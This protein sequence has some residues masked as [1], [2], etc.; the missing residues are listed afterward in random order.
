VGGSGKIC[1]WRHPITHLSVRRVK[2][3]SRRRK[4]ALT[5]IRNIYLYHQGLL[6]VVIGSLFS[7]VPL[8][9]ATYRKAELLSIVLNDVDR[10]VQCLESNYTCVYFQ[11]CLRFCSQRMKTAAREK[12]KKSSV[13]YRRPCIYFRRCYSGTSRFRAHDGQKRSHST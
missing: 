9:C 13:R 4:R 6:R 3:L 10:Y 8:S 7:N 12:K 1:Q 5:G 11:R 2:K